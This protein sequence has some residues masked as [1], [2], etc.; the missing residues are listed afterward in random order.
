M[1]SIS[2]GNAETDA[3]RQLIRLA[4]AEDLGQAGDITSQAVIPREL[5]GKAIFVARTDG[6][7]SGSPIVSL[8]CSAIDPDLQVELHSTDGSTLQPKQV[9]A[10]L[11]GSM[12]S[13]LA[14]ER[15]ALNFLQKLSG[16]ATQTSKYVEQV[17]NTQCQV[18]DTRKTTPGWRVLEKYAVRCGGGRNHRMGLYDAVMIK[19][20]HLA[21]LRH[22]GTPLAEAVRQARSTVEPG[23]MV[24]VEVENID[25][26]EEALT[27]HP[28]V[29]LLDNMKLDMMRAAVEL[30]NRKAPE[31]KLEASG[32]ITL[33]TLKEVARTGVDYVSVGAL[34]HSAQALDIALDYQE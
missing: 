23:I 30:R 32:G 34:T 20:N 2:F 24:E 29:I 25:Q 16:I 33:S 28:D 8:V 9:I 10:K 22:H 31:T 26:M 11:S 6:V 13:I 17:R 5:Q 14:V 21:G 27:V 15:T 4:I 18:L 7:L 12:R 19:D 1:L 3:A